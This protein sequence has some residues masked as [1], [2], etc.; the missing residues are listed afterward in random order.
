MLI[1]TS[2]LQPGGWKVISQEEEIIDG[3]KGAGLLQRFT[4]ANTRDVEFLDRLQYET[5]SCP[6]LI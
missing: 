5:R 2:L 1:K 3:N 6:H 4:I